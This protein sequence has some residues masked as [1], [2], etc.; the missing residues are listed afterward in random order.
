[1]APAQ[2]SMMWSG[3]ILNHKSF[4]SCCSAK[5]VYCHLF[6]HFF[7]YSQLAYYCSNAHL[8]D[9]RWINIFV[10]LGRSVLI[11]I[12]CRQ[13]SSR[14]SIFLVQTFSIQFTNL[15]HRLNRSSLI[16]TTEK[17]HCDCLTFGVLHFNH[18]LTYCESQC[19]GKSAV[20]YEYSYMFWIP[21]VFLI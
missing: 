2:H 13:F 7:F 12:V 10:S 8:C 21:L 5:K 15:V 3:L 9:Q 18:K 20:S 19:T 4:C 11:L 16:F 6:V 17:S 1:M 14:Y